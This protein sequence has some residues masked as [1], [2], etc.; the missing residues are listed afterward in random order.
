[1]NIQDF[2]FNIRNFAP[3]CLLSLSLTFA[4]FAP[5]RA[6]L[7]EGVDAIVNKKAIFK[8]DVDKFRVLFPLRLKVD[9]LFSNDPISKNPKLTDEEIVNFLIDEE[10]IVE[11]F[12]VTDSDVEQE[13]TGIQS[14]LHID[15][16]ALR[17][18]ILREGFKFE[19]YFSLMRVSLSKRQLI[20]REIRNKAAVSDDDLKAE[21]NRE[22]AGSKNFH[23]SFHLFLIKFPKKS[24]KTAALAKDEATKTLEAIRKDKTIEEMS[25]K[26]SDEGSPTQGGDM[27][28]LSYGEMSESLQ[29][30]VR[31]L[32]PNGVS[33]IADDGDSYIIVKVGDIKSELDEGFEKQKDSLRGKLMEGEFHH[34]IKLW[35]E[36]QRSSNYIKIN[37]KK[38]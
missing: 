5:A 31:K 4:S 2:S 14:N 3:F 13:I 27:G 20:D 38:P 36:L 17:A 16:E 24:Y 30:E 7:I 34:Q 35:L 6:E 22:Q 12:P 25:K 18:A 21:Y 11:K 23:G 26:L 29:K 10:I 1:M 28:F 15:R 19:E 8:S 32:G 33:D 37:L 9:P